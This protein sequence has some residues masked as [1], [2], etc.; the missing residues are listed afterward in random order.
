MQEFAVA[1]ELVAQI[2]LPNPKMSKTET[3]V[4]MYGSACQSMS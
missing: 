3:V 4:L 1:V 2:D